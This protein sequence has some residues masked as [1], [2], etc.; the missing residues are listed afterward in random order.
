MT[1]ND[2]IHSY[3]HDFIMNL[4]DDKKA[5]V[6]LLK[7][8]LLND[9]GGW[10]ACY[11]E[12]SV[13]ESTGQAVGTVA[14]PHSPLPDVDD[15]E[16]ESSILSSGSHSHSTPRLKEAEGDRLELPP[17]TPSFE[18]V[19][20]RLPPMPP[21]KRSHENTAAEDNDN[22]ESYRLSESDLEEMFRK[23]PGPYTRKSGRYG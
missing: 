22:M 2:L 23:S 9:G 5:K 15:S 18:E 12:D 17:T 7:G 3:V 13:E 20:Q 1:K 19:V 4:P 6:P 11:D 10:S 16:D 14:L 8:Y 21:G